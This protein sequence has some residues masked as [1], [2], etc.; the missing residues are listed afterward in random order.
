MSGGSPVPV[1]NYF[2]IG[3][4]SA[5]ASRSS[6]AESRS[7]EVR[8][9]P[10]DATSSGASTPAERIVIECERLP[11]SLTAIR[12]DPCGLAGPKGPSPRCSP[13]D[14][15]PCAR[16]QSAISAPA[17]PPKI[18]STT[19]R[20]RVARRD[21]IDHRGEPPPPDALFTAARSGAPYLP[22]GLCSGRPARPASQPVRAE[23]LDPATNSA[24]LFPVSLPFHYGGRSACGER[25][26]ATARPIDATCD[27]AVAIRLVTTRCRRFHDLRPSAARRRRAAPRHDRHAAVRTMSI[28]PGDPTFS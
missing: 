12:G 14:F 21:P 17:R 10:C 27:R 6:I 24:T 23:P 13:A 20:V 3:G 2:A 15:P 8:A 22:R 28:S 5:V 18:P 4:P 9:H 19:V 1:R 25:V 26:R 11:T 16:P 7:N